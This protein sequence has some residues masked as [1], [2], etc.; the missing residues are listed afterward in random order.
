MPVG[1]AISVP[2]RY[3]RYPVTPTSSVEALQDTATSEKESAV[4]VTFVGVLG[5]EVSVG[6]ETETA[7]S[8][9]Q[10]ASSNDPMPTRPAPKVASFACMITAP[11]AF[12]VMSEPAR[13]TSIW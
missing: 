12:T 3:S 6:A 4:A 11:S 8:S 9:H 1:D 5:A 13:E 2:S 10:A 7:M